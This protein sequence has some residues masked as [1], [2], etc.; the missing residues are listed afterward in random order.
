M[1]DMPPRTAR[2]SATSRKVMHRHHFGNRFLVNRLNQAV[3]R[4]SETAQLFK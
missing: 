3:R 4:K 2:Q 1:S